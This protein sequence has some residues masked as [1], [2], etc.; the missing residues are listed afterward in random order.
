[1]KTISTPEE[2]E[3][4]LGENMKALRLQKNLARKTLCNRA[5][6]SENALRNL[7]GGKGTTLKTLIRALKALHQETWL[8]K[9]A[10]KTSIHPLHLTNE[11]EQRQRARRK[12]HDENEI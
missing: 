9:I 10:P 3:Y 4:M 11:K 8:E 12:K 5:G 2:L 7:E 6:I 1:M